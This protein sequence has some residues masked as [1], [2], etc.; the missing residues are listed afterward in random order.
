VNLGRAELFAVRAHGGQLQPTG[1]PL[2]AHV[3]RVAAATPQ[4][5]RPV[6]WL[7]EVLEWTSVSEEALLGEGVSDD[8]LR[9][10]RLLT[11]TLARRSES[12]YLAHATMI[13]RAG[14]RAGS[15]ARSV[16][17]SDLNDRLRYPGPQG[18]GSRPPYERALRL[19]LDRNA[20][21][22]ARLPLV[23]V[24]QLGF[25]GSVDVAVDVVGADAVDDSVSL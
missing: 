9:A 15:L 10:L 6:A 7:H 16:K 19:I 21:E 22:S 1:E 23:G 25:D 8:E 11:R 18:N 14:G 3:R 12:G 17:V 2:I 5:A 20:A 13:A 4:F 24:G